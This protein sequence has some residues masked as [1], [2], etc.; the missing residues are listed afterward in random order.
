LK[1]ILRWF[2]PKYLRVATIIV[3]WLAAAIY[4]YALAADRFVSESVVVVRSNTEA[5]LIVSGLSAIFPTAGSSTQPDSL[6]LRSYIHS[7]DMLMEVDKRLG[8]R[9]AYSAPRADFWFRL[10]NSASREQLLEYFRN[11]VDVEYDEESGLL[12]IR[13]EAFEPQYSAR[14]NALLIEL[15]ERFINETSHRIARS[16][17]EFARSEQLLAQDAL[18][19]AKQAVQAFQN[20]YGVLDP[21]AQ[22]QANTGVTVELQG[23]LARQEAELK[24]MLGYLSNNAPQ[25]NTLRQQIAGTRA[26]LEAEKKRGTASGARLNVLAGEFEA[27]AA[28]LEFAQEAYKGAT[29]GM[30]SARI[31]SVR[32]LKTLVAVQ[33]PGVPQQAERPRRAYSL[34]AVFL[35]LC[36]VYGI[37]RLTVAT[38][39]DHIG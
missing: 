5:P 37:A 22:A 31:E 21:L 18:E 29:A 39:E 4:L 13:T 33:T 3:P 20:Q 15:S 11:R 19:K 25:V 26:Q 9:A 10:D 24:G 38:I 16:Q 14:L 7:S 34:L 1:Q 36:L 17:M 30:E 6:M 35:G 8:L 27:L 12:K 2:G 28:R 32:K 23:S